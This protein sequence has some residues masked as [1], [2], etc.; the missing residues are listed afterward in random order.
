MNKRCHRAVLMSALLV[1]G[2]QHQAPEARTDNETEVYAV[3]SARDLDDLALEAVDRHATQVLNM[4]RRALRRARFTLASCWDSVDT[5]HCL[6]W[7]ISG[8]LMACRWR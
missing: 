7:P 4:L 6:H 3:A 5:S 2:C 1:A 8:R